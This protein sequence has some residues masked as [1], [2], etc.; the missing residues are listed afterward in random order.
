MSTKIGQK[1]SRPD[2]RAADLRAGLLRSR[3]R[4]G[5]GGSPADCRPQHR[6]FHLRSLAAGRQRS[7]QCFFHV[8]RPDPR[9]GGVSSFS[10]P[11][12][13]R[14]G[15]ALRQPAGDALERSGIGN[16]HS[17]F[18]AEM[19]KACSKPPSPATTR[20]SS[21]IT[22]GCSTCAATC[23]K[24][25]KPIPFGVADVKRKG[26]DVTV[27]AT[28]YTVQRCLQVAEK[29]ANEKIK[30]KSSTH[31]RWCRSTWRPC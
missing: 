27:I 12:R 25:T 24:T 31:A 20:R 30:W 9:A 5:D 18:A 17:V 3:H 19:S 15:A 13:R 23:R 1:I 10:R 2:D 8:R 29:L 16:R 11:A 14:R 7:G 22:P 26:S 21:S 28:S 6:K 4:R